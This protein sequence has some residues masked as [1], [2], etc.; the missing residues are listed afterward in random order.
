MR[1]G[2]IAVVFAF[3]V[4]ASLVLGGC[5]S[6][7]Q[8]VARTRSMALANPAETSLGR[9]VEANVRPGGL[10]GIRLLSSGEEALRSL[11]ALADRA[12]RTLDIQY[13]IIHQDESSRALLLAYSFQSVSAV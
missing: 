4:L 6:L 2:A 5:A 10:S 3:P 1:T 12:E 11:I 9:L 7:P 8:H 13:Y